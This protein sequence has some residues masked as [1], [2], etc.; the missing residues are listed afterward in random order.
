M[1]KRYILSKYGDRWKV[2]DGHGMWGKLIVKGSK[3]YCK[4]E[5]DK[6]NLDHKI[7]SA[8]FEDAE[9]RGKKA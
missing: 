2:T 8:A 7:R 4:D 9:K 6:L 3:E 1:T 5:A